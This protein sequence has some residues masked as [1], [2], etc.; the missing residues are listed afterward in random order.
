MCVANPGP[1]ARRVNYLLH[2][3]GVLSEEQRTVSR[4][5]GFQML[6]CRCD[7]VRS[8]SEDAEGG[9]SAQLRSQL[10]EMRLGVEHHSFT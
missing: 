6:R 3:T 5:R 1:A 9:A 4:A 2:L 10:R 8:I 7:L